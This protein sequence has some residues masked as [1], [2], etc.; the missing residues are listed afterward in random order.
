MPR[1]ITPIAIRTTDCLREIRERA[2]R[3]RSDELLGC[4]ELSSLALSEGQLR[5]P[6]NATFP[7]PPDI[8]LCD[9]QRTIAFEVSRLTWQ[10]LSQVLGEATKNW[11]GSQVELDHALLEN[12]K[13]RRRKGKTK[14]ERSGDYEAIKT[15]GERLRGW[16]PPETT[17][18]MQQPTRC[19]P[20]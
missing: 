2:Y 10:R 19:R 14:G 18:F 13:A 17:T 1:K 4:A 12:G 9:D 6:I 15:T 5:L 20:R 11:P 8:V 16:V 7:D 3:E